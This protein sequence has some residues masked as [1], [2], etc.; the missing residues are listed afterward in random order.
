MIN[1]YT[2]VL[3]QRDYYQRPLEPLEIMITADK[4]DTT[5]KTLISIQ[6]DIES[7]IYD[8]TLSIAIEVSNR[9]GVDTTDYASITDKSIYL[10]FG[11][12]IFSDKCVLL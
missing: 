6:V 3:L 10:S 12:D 1:D 7:L 5:Q 11:A 9:F 8:S 2:Y 4:L